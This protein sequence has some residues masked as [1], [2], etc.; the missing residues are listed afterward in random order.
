M[1]KK[2]AET[3]QTQTRNHHRYPQTRDGTRPSNPEASTR[4]P[5]SRW[6][7]R[8]TQSRAGNAQASTLNESPGPTDGRSTTLARTRARVMSA[9]RRRL[10]LRTSR[11]KFGQHTMRGDATS[12]VSRPCYKLNSSALLTPR[13]SPGKRS[14]GEW[15]KVHDIVCSA[16]SMRTEISHA[17]NYLIIRLEIV[18]PQ[19]ARQDGT[20]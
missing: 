9:R 8:T 3:R 1:E 5:R 4:H 12:Y 16:L 13:R 15:K 11:C 20:Y 6:R 18:G 19:R 7:G 10:W 14:T 2:L 17:L